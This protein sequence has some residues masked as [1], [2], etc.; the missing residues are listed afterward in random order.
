VKLSIEKLKELLPTARP[1][2]RGSNLRAICPWCGQ[3][4]FG[5][6]I[7]N[8][9][10]FGCYRKKKCG[11]SGNIFTLA[12]FLRRWDLL[13]IEGEVGKVEKLENKIVKANIEYNLDLPNVSMPVGW[14]RVMQDEYL[15]SRGF[16]EYARYKVGRTQVDPRFKKNYVITAI[17]EG[18]ETKGYIGRHIWD[19]E[20]I[21]IESAIRV[22]VGGKEILRYINS[23]T[24]FG[25][26]L[27]GYDEIAEGETKTVICVE[28]IFDKWNI[29]R[30]LS[31]HNQ[32]GIKCN[33]TFKCDISPEQIIKWQIKGIETLIL[34]YDPDVINEIK[35]SAA[36]LQLYFKIFVAFNEAGADPGD[37]TKEQLGEVFSNLKSPSEFSNNKVS[38]NII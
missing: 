38:F 34:F 25:K 13:N 5:I 3:D 30:L 7:E 26:L 20:K 31:L 32:E 4:E 18:G 14:K 27:M 21:K 1:D 23:D 9:H 24:D 17:E 33:A 16:T 37:I 19:K 29:D 12:K 22:K 28:G 36:S 6:S 35:K 2:R 8:N 10:V 15:A 11:V